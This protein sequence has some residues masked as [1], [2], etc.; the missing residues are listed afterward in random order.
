M[1]Q[2]TEL[3]SFNSKIILN[4]LLDLG[5]GFYGARAR[6]GHIAPDQIT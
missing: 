1:L 6:S 2:F 4:Y 5:L 3:Y